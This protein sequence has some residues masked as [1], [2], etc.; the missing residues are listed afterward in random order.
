MVDLNAVNYPTQK[1]YYVRRELLGGNMTAK[2]FGTRRLWQ[3][4]DPDSVGLYV[5][6]A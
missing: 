3:E 1:T 6:K 5:P 2:G 4:Y